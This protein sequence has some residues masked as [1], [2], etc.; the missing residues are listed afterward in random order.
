MEK[1]NRIVI[2]SSQSVTDLCVLG[3]QYPTDK[4]PYTSIEGMARHGYTAVYDLLLSSKRYEPLLL[5]EAGIAH[6]MSMHMWRSYFPQAILYGWDFDEKLLE[7]AKAQKIPRC[8]YGYINMNDINSVLDAFNSAGA[9]FDILIDDTTHACEHQVLFVQMALRFM[10]PGGLI[11]IEDVFRQWD[12]SRYN[13][14]LRPYFKY[15][16]SGTFI[17]TNHK[18]N[19]SIGNTPPYFDN[20]KLLVL[21]RNHELAGSLQAPL[22]PDPPL[23]Q[24]ARAR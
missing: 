2:D 23:A 13:D 1:L 14:A 6:N 20:D 5:G 24:Q 12:E 9:N 4:S 8:H 19:L 16:S 3:A 22:M 21:T 10:K 18:N 7:T 17:E 11:I 15:F